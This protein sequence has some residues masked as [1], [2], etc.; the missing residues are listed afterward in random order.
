MKE[1]LLIAYDGTENSLKAVSYA[2]RLIK[3]APEHFEVVL[4]FVLPPLPINII[5]YGDLP[6]VSP[7]EKEK[8]KYRKELLEELQKDIEN[9]SDK[10]F[11]R[12]LELFKTYGINSKISTKFSHCTSDVAGEIIKE[13]ET[14]QY[15]TIVLGR[16]GKS[17]IKE[18]LL[19]GTAEKVIRYVRNIA[20]WVVE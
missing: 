13:A 11:M 10:I 2:A 6:N 17:S 8:I 18:R 16:K 14:G 12:P 1:K 7:D 3:L 5:E 15:T 19:G 20:I 4:Y 9:R